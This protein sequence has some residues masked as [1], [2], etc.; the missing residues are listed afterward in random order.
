MKGLAGM[1]RLGTLSGGIADAGFASLAT[2]AVGLVATQVLEPAPLG[3]YANFF[4]AFLVGTVIPAQ[5]TFTPA[6]V[7]SVSFPMGGRARVLR[8]SIR[9]GLGAALLS[10]AVMLLP[11]AAMW[12]FAEPG[13]IFMLTSTGMVAAFLSPIQDHV[14]RVL[15][16]DDESWR[17]AT[18]SIIQ[19]ATIAVA[20]LVMLQ[21]G[22]ATEWIPFGALSIANTVSLTSGLLIARLPRLEALP[23]DFTFRSLAG[24]GR[25]LVASQVV[26]TG[27]V[28]LA[29]VIIA[30]LASAEALGYAEA[31]RIAAQPVLVL[32]F[33]L[34]AVAAPRAMS[35]AGRRD[36][37]AARRVRR[38]FFVAL[39]GFSVVYLAVAG[40]AWPGNPMLYLVENAYEVPG[41]TA[42]AILGN[43][44][45]GSNYAG[46]AELTG[47][48]FER[49]LAR[50]NFYSSATL[51]ASA[52]LGGIIGAFAR[53][54]GVLLQGL[55][56]HGFYV[57][58]LRRMYRT[59]PTE[60]SKRTP[61]NEPEPV[62]P[63]T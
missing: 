15:I 38:F 19:F 36:R 18:V 53:P 25:W 63:R 6:E 47:G 40:F 43:A 22:I 3:V 16:Q 28:F 5:L 41:L 33:G 34:A 26:P 62:S 13:T 35:A 9:A 8:R 59:P 29:T 2:F 50:F 49:D 54:L 45:N 55:T 27:A 20:V 10:S 24:T 12:S 32:G 14:R 1:T 61:S 17:A 39:G 30:H 51:L 58:G 44:W 42:L 4:A 57:R 11:A 46:Q 60:T 7:I 37:D 21:L 31:S 48:E 56:K 23:H 52:F